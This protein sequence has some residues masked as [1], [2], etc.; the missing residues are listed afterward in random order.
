MFEWDRTKA[1]QNE[2]KHGVFFSDSF[3]VFEDSNALT[4][5]QNIDGE[6]RYVT[7]GMDGF[8][9]ILVVVYTWRDETIR[10]ISARK[11][12]RSEVRQYEGEL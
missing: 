10:I 9:R 6:E 1:I 8:G 11:A 2:K 7:V 4:I 12:T 5:D 3:A